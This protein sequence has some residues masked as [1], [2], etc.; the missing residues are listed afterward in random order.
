MTW[1]VWLLIVA[2]ASGV[3]LTATKHHCDD[4]CVDARH[5]RQETL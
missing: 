4:L 1:L 5:G 2:T 3:W